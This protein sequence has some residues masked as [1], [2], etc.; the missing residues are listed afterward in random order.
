MEYSKNISNQAKVVECKK[1][2]ESNYIATVQIEFVYADIMVPSNVKVGSFLQ[3]NSEEVLNVRTEHW[4]GV[5]QMFKMLSEH[6]DFRSQVPFEEINAKIAELNANSE[7]SNAKNTIS[8]PHLHWSYKF[9]DDVPEFYKIL[10]K[11][12]IFELGH[13]VDVKVM[14]GKVSHSLRMDR[15][16]VSPNEFYDFATSHERLRWVIYRGNDIVTGYKMA[17]GRVKGPPAAAAVKA[18]RKANILNS[19]SRWVSENG[20]EFNCKLN[21]SKMAKRIESETWKLVKLKLSRE[22][23]EK[24]SLSGVIKTDGTS[25]GYE[26]ISKYLK[27]LYPRNK[28]S[29]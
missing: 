25:L 22:E 23:K 14:D 18:E 13:F 28:I 10:I 29:D 15:V 20:Q 26:M 6:G 27:E 1:L 11:P 12:I 16:K 2:N 7:G 24:H 8:I 21:R 4:G 17:V 5:S 9:N 3:V 19:I